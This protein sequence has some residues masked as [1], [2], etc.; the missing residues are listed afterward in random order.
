MKMPGMVTSSSRL[1]RG[2]SMRILRK[3]LG[4]ALVVGVALN[5][6]NYGHALY[7][8]DDIPWA[9]LLFNFIV[10]FCVSLYTGVSERQ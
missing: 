7:S 3:A 8:G 4:V 6:A 2:M 1:V 10:P 5:L 9:G